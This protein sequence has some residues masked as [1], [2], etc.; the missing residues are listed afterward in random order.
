M[1]IILIAIVYPTALTFLYFDLLANA[2]TV[3]QQ[4]IYALG[5]ALQ[6]GFPA[7]WTVSV[8]KEK[9]EVRRPSMT[10]FVWGIGSGVGI[11]VAT[12]LAVHLWLLPA[13]YLATAVDG[14]HAK[15]KGMGVDSPFRYIALAA[16]YALGHSGLEEY[17]WRWFVFGRLAR[18]TSVSAAILWSSVGFIAHHILIVAQ[19][20]GWSSPL[21]YA[22]PPFV[23]IGGAG[24]AWLYQRTG[25]LYGPWISHLFVDAA[26]FFIGFELCFWGIR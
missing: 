25:S 19:F 22:L 9:I 7:V 20:F 24:W 10:D 11:L 6:F 14:I 23:A 26:I 18:R 5:K 17:Y 3:V 8:L 4:G 16:F 1:L 2:P 21:T 12:S 15:I 13:G